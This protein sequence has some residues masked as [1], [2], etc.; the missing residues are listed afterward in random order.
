MHFQRDTPNNIQVRIYQAAGRFQGVKRPRR[1]ILN[2]DYQI[3]KFWGPD[4]LFQGQK[5]GFEFYV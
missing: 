2:P 4:D 1:A 5:F 3:V